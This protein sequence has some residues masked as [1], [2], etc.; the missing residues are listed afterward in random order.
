MVTSTPLYIMVAVTV[1]VKSPGEQPIFSVVAR[2]TTGNSL[3]SFRSTVKVC[4]HP[5]ARC[6]TS[7]V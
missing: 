7:M 2:V 6:N 5:L 1:P 4:V 3:A